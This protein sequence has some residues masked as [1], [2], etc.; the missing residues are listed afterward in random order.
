MLIVAV[1]AVAVGIASYA[2]VKDDPWAKRGSGLPKTFTL[3]LKDL[4]N[5]DPDLIR[6]EQTAQFAVPLQ[7]VRAIAVGPERKIYV[8]GN[9]AVHVFHADGRSQMVIATKGAPSCIAVGPSDHAAPGRIYVGAGRRIEL[10]DPDGKPAGTW[11]GFDEMAMLTSIA[12]AKNDV[13]VAD[14][15]NRVVLR[16]DASGKLVGK[17]GAPD[18]DREMPGFIVPSPHF[19]VAV[20]PEGL[21]YVANPGVG[22]IETYTLDGDLEAFWGKAGPAIGDFFGCC[23]PSQF[24]LLPSGQFVTSEKGIPR[25][26]VYS[27]AG[28]LVCVV[29]GPQQLEVAESEIGDPRFSSGQVVFDVAT[30]D[31]GHV[32]VLDPRK[33]SVRIFTPTD[34][35]KAAER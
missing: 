34:T 19:D 2:I 11:E 18:P 32:L 23:N 27:N 33:R 9:R 1:V 8:A 4:I 5:V 26:K 28:E 31:Q 29:A 7:Q 15:G 14:A 25:I 30:D 16:Y 12:V 3:D 20:D 10:F 24:A 21:I 6:F 35:T 22:R 17:I 13:F